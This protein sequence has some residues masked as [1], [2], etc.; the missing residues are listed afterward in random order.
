MP[1]PVTDTRPARIRDIPLVKRLAEHGTVL[2][3]EMGCTRENGG[4]NNALLSNILFP[5]RSLYTLVGAQW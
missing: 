2:D 3:S 5:Q 1:G 4:P